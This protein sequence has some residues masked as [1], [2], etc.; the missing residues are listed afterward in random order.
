MNAVISPMAGVVMAILVSE[1]QTIA[2]G[3]HVATLE[4]MKMEI[5]V[6]AEVSGSVS[7][8][9]VAEGETV[10]QDDVLFELAVD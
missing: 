3:S 9:R 2:A 5:P 1:G 10:N 6:I 8:I 7:T 4:S